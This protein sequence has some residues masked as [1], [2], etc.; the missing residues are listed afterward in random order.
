VWSKHDHLFH[1]ADCDGSA[2]LQGRMYDDP[3][4]AR[5]RENLTY[6]V[7][8]CGTV[9][10]PGVQTDFFKGGVCLGPKTLGE[11]RDTLPVEMVPSLVLEKVRGGGQGLAGGGRG[12]PVM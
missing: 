7:E 4:V 1:Q 3:E 8:P 6:H 9:K 2:L 5:R 11:R 12:L 10:V